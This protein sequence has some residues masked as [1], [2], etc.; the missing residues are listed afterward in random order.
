MLAFHGTSQAG[1]AAKIASARQAAAGRDLGFWINL[2]MIAGSTDQQARRHLEDLEQAIRRLQDFR[3]E[4]RSDI[5]SIR[6][7]RFAH[8]GP[9]ESQRVRQFLG[10]LYVRWLRRGFQPF[11]PSDE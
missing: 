11:G 10:A 3:L 8:L 4:H 1:A 2:N 9:A 6:E 5:R 7:D